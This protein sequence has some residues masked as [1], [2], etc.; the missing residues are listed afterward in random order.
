[1]VFNYDRFRIRKYWVPDEKA[2]IR[3]L[4]YLFAMRREVNMGGVEPDEER[5][6]H[7][8]GPCLKVWQNAF[9]IAA[10]C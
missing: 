3:L 10:Y 9:K 1:M 5:K 7:G 4:T 6:V 2:G 8:V